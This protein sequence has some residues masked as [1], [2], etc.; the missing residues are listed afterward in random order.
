MRGTTRTVETMVVGGRRVPHRAIGVHRAWRYHDRRVAWALRRLAGEID[1]VHTWPAACVRTLTA[2]RRLGVRALREAPSPH[3]ESAFESAAKEA[4][5]QGVE[6]PRRHH[7]RAHPWRVELERREYR[8]AEVLLAPSEYV[9]RSFVERGVPPEKLARHHYGFEPERFPMPCDGRRSADRPFTA[10][11]VGR[12]EPNKGLHYALQA[13]INSGAAERGRF[14]ICGDFLPAYR[15]RLRPLL[16]HSSVEVRGFVHDVGAVMREAD[17]LVLP[18]VTE[19]SALVTYEA[20]ASGCVLVVSDAAGALCRHL[21]QGLVHPAGDVATLTEHLRMLDRDRA[22]LA[23]LRA[24]TLA[25]RDELTWS[26]AAE[27]L[28][29]IYA[30]TQPA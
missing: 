3:V 10:V 15:D 26:R 6:L 13:W 11:F 28:V 23:R 29:Q 27:R 22:L 14:V 4:R 9:E 18:T 12:C 8:A 16:A 24:A 20:Q 30:A 1:I 19:G 7:H 17:V 5:A 2:A 21:E 25:R